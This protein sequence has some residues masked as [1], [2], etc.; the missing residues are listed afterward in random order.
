MNGAAAS[1][2]SATAAAATSTAACC[3]CR[4]LPS[5][6]NPIRVGVFG[7]QAQGGGWLDGLGCSRAIFSVLKVVNI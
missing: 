2:R 7:F 4:V 6:K 3:A 1:T 5:L